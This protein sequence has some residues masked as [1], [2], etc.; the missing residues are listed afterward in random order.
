MCVK[1]YFQENDKRLS[2]DAEQVL[3]ELYRCVRISNTSVDK[4]QFLATVSRMPQ[5]GYCDEQVLDR[6]I[7]KL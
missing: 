1:N 3:R 2:C 4:K 5:F 6:F 7:K